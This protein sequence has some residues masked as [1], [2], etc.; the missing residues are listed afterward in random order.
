[1]LRE[2]G[3]IES[4]ADMV[5]L[6]EQG[7]SMCL[8]QLPFARTVFI[9]AWTD[10]VI[11]QENVAARLTHASQMLEA[12]V[13]DHIDAGL[14]RPIDPALATQMVL[15]M[16]LAPILPVLRGVSPTPSPEEVRALAEGSVS[17]LLDGIRVR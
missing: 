17:L 7:L 2:A 8:S 15:G 9:E 5:A 11:L 12:F 14:F 6:V 13:R 4:E 10:D 3:E 1:V 16:F